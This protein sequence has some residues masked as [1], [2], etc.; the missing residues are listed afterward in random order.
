[1]DASAHT[2]HLHDTDDKINEIK[3]KM[4]RDAIHKWNPKILEKFKTDSIRTRD[5]F[6]I[7]CHCGC[8]NQVGIHSAIINTHLTKMKIDALFDYGFL[9]PADVT[10]LSKMIG[11]A[12]C[13]I[14]SGDGEEYTCPEE[15][16][17]LMKKLDKQA[18]VAWRD[19]EYNNT[20]LHMWCTSHY[21]RAFYMRDILAYLVDECGIDPAAESHV[22]LESEDWEPRPASVGSHGHSALYSVVKDLDMASIRYLFQKGC[23]S[24]SL[25]R[26]D[27]VFRRD[28]LMNIV[29]PYTATYE[30]QE[31][32]HDQQR[33]TKY[34]EHKDKSITECPDCTKD[35][36]RN[37]VPLKDSCVYD[38]WHVIRYCVTEAGYDVEQ[39]DI[40]GKTL[41]DHIADMITVRP[42]FGTHILTW[43]DAMIKRM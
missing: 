20:I 5:C 36:N 34:C 39:A 43:Y 28:V 27:D 12:G 15:L 30:A 22:V 4:Y 31:R 6:T 1:M 42:K 11:Y 2:L 23:P 19:P 41:R 25:L 16:I 17:Y 18:L 32:K 8:A 9:M 13:L 10:L 24:G 37:F 40:D 35:V 3:N 38:I 14:G 7:T 26:E 29:F 33:H 21:K